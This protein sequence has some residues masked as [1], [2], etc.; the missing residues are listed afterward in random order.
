MTRAEQTEYLV[1]FPGKRVRT[2]EG[3]FQDETHLPAAQQTATA[4]PRISPPDVDSGGQADHF[5][6]SRQGAE[7]ARRFGQRQ[8]VT[9][10]GLGKARTRV[11]SIRLTKTEMLR[12]DREYRDVVRRG[13]RASTPHYSIY[14]DF[15]ASGG[16]GGVPVSRKI[17][18]S[19]GRRVG[20]AVVRN[21]VKR[22]LREFYRHNKR[23]F[24]VGT[25]TA[26]VVRKVPRDA[27]LA[28]V[29]AELLSAIERSWGK[30]REPTPCEQETS[31]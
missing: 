17:G 31:R 3:V 12:T 25:R 8:E 28:S 30:R 19:V 29:S 6:T 21:R 23:V 1:F 27:D 7:A 9:L 16:E 22:L 11:V 2:K 15:R 13:E 10:S 4:N 18:I 26:I 20:N 24:P 5:P 14:R